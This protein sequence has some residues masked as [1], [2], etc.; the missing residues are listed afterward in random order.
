MIP[1]G[2]NGLDLVDRLATDGWACLAASFPYELFRFFGSS[3]WVYGIF[4]ASSHMAT[5]LAVCLAG[6]QGWPWSLDRRGMDGWTG[7][8]APV[9]FPTTHPPSP[10][11]NIPATRF[12]ALSLRVNSLDFFCFEF[13]FFSLVSILFPSF[14]PRRRD[15]CSSSTVFGFGAVNHH[16]RSDEISPPTNLLRR[17]DSWQRQE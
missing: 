2:P 4:D 15:C 11:G 17:P 9:S 3:L 6:R 7:R 8:Q 10:Q 16:R 12:P 13:A 1:W 5:K 14:F